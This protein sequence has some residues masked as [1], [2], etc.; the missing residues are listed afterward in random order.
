MSYKR[1][2]KFKA[3]LS[4]EI[5]FFYNLWPGDKVDF[6]SIV[7]DEDTG[8]KVVTKEKSLEICKLLPSFCYDDDDIHEVSESFECVRHDDDMLSLT[9]TICLG[10][11]EFL[12]GIQFKGDRIMFERTYKI[13]HQST[14]NEIRDFLL[15]EQK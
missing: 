4:N 15:Q 12:S 1:K 11:P 3:N 5:L 14:I 9:Q 6:K 10:E 8:A 13:H 2:I 7:I